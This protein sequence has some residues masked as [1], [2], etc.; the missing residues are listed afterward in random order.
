[1]LQKIGLDDLFDRVARLGQGRRNGFNP[2]R[3]AA[4]VLGQQV[5]VTAV[6]GIEAKMIDAKP[7]QGVVGNLFGQTALPFHRDE[8]DDT[9]LK[10]PNFFVRFLT[11]SINARA[12]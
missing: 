2:D 3:P 11:L 10:P 1:M 4:I 6:V 12:R 5:H 8:I 7:G 9:A